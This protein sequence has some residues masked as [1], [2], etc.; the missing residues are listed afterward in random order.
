MREFLRCQKL[1]K[2]PVLSVFDNCQKHLVRYL[3]LRER[4][5]YLTS[6]VF[7]PYPV[8]TKYLTSDKV[9]T[10]MKRKE[11]QIAKEMPRLKHWPD[12]SRPFSRERS[13]V[14]QW[15]IRQPEIQQ[16]IFALAHENK[17]IRYDSATE[18]WV[19]VNQIPEQ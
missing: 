6:G 15:L 11:L 7:R 12:K 2:I 14:I 8:V 18:T 17:L 16:L 9:I 3:P 1:S 5:Y 10:Q 19:G 13:E 4:R